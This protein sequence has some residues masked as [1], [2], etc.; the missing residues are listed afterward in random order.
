MIMSKTSIAI[1]PGET[2]KEQLEYRNMTQKEF[3]IRMDMSQKH[4]SKLINGEV[5]LTH[6]MANRLEMVLGVPAKFWNNLE[7]VYRESIIRINT[8]NNIGS[9]MDL[10]RC[11]PYKEI[12][13]LGWIPDTR[14]QV[15]KTINLRKFFEVVDLT[16]LK[17]EQFINMFSYKFDINDKHDAALITWAQKARLLSRDLDIKPVDNRK[18][19]RALSEFDNKSNLASKKSK[20]DLCCKMADYGIALIEVPSLKD[21]PCQSLSF[22]S[23]KI[24]IIEVTPAKRDQSQ[25]F[26][27]I[28]KELTHAVSIPV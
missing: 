5:Q 8:E 14:D 18:L 21:L 23:G 3:A 22:S 24:I 17:S 1:P 20:N 28:Y 13:G 25:F 2:I 12:A 4:I 7:S 26:K 11:F 19:N 10:A 15:E 16:L 6:E 27:D 9:E